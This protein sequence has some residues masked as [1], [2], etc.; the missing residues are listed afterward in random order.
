LDPDEA[1][2]IERLDASAQ[3]AAF[4][5]AWTAK[6][7]LVKTTGAGIARGL[8]HLT[9]LPREGLRVTL[10]NAIADDMRALTAQW[11]AAPRGYA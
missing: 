9:V 7:A 1:A 8:Q 4:Y 10:R 5:D 11:L 3:P 2:W 6:E